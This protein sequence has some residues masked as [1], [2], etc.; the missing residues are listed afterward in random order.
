MAN[1]KN[2]EKT[3]V[4]DGKKKNRKRKQNNNYYLDIFGQLNIYI[5]N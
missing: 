2:D 5:I 1:S 4:F 3:K